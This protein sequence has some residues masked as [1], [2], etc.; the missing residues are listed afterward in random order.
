M[1]LSERV[2]CD[3]PC[4]ADSV[5]RAA[6]AVRRF[7]RSLWL[8]LVR[9]D[10]SERWERSSGVPVERYFELLP[11]LRKSREEAL[12]LVCS[13]V[14]VRCASG[15]HVALNDLA[16]RFPDLADDLAI[17]F[18]LDSVLG[19]LTGDVR[20]SSEVK[21]ESIHLPGFQILRLLG[22][23]ASS[24]V[25]LARQISVDRLVAIK[26][27]PLWNLNEWQLRRHSQEASIL[28][29]M[30]HPNVVRIYDVIEADGALYSVIEY[31]GGP[32]LAQFIARQPQ[33]PAAAAR[34]VR[35]LAKALH[36]VHEAGILHRDLKPSNVLMTSS[37]EPKITDFGLAKLSNDGDLT[38]AHCLLGTPSYMPPEQ[39]GGDSP[40]FRE[41]DIYSLGSIL[42]E[43]LTGFPPFL[44]MTI[45][46][47]LTM[48]REQDPI[49]PRSSQPLIPRDLE[50]ICLKCLSKSPH[51][52]YP[53]GEELADDLGRFLAGTTIR[54]PRPAVLERAAR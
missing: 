19:N 16:R 23:G 32:T 8:D 14:R 1:M 25:Y 47:T 2:E 42:Y 38:T 9:R 18:E 41:G 10:Q 45:L 4:S 35:V 53:S 5:E 31:V 48:I 7:K 11:E 3:S 21:P 24:R 43:L 28:F 36:A 30:Q 39:T 44:G 40:T 6:L 34:L 26:V 22:R 49:P 13:E 33:A 29:R 12:V 37:G 27:I 46:D 20:E 54:A 17:Q 52:R 15:A 50:T 51:A